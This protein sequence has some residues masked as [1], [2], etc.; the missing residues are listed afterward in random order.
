MN[1]LM[2]GPSNLSAMPMKHVNAWPNNERNY[3][4]NSNIRISVCAYNTH[5][6][7]NECNSIIV[8]VVTVIAH[9]GVYIIPRIK[10][11]I[12]IVNVTL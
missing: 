6:R 4:R 1:H 7:L 3:G 2:L 9:I 11:D 5:G 10:N 12:I 8:H